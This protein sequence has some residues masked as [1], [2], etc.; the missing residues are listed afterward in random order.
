MGENGEKH[1]ICFEPA[2][3]NLWVVNGIWPFGA[4][5][6]DQSLD[7]VEGFQLA[8]PLTSLSS[9]EKPTPAE[10]ATRHTFNMMWD[11]TVECALKRFCE[12]RKK[13]RKV[14]SPT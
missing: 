2:K 13:K 8:Y 5:Q 1:P 6:E 10:I 14:P 9:A 4:P 3:Q 11:T 12:K 7:K